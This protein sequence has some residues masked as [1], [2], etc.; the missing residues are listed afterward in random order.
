MTAAALSSQLQTAKSA[1]EQKSQHLSPANQARLKAYERNTMDALRDVQG[2]ARNH[3]LRNFYEHTAQ[4]N[5]R[6]GIEF[7][8]THFKTA[9]PSHNP[10]LETQ[11]SNSQDSQDWE[12]E[13]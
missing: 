11:H 1:Y 6:Y 9:T 2:N 12:M 8:P 10:T 4:K 13:R 7:A 3:A 5:E